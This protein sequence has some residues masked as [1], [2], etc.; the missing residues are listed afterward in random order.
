[1][2]APLFLYLAFVAAVGVALFAGVVY[3][4]G[5]AAA[6]NRLSQHGLTPARSAAAVA[7]ALTVTAVLHLLAGPEAVAA[8]TAGRRAVLRV[9]VWVV[10]L[11]AGCEGI[12]GAVGLARRWRRLRADATTGRIGSRVAVSG[13]VTATATSPAPVTGREAVCWSWTVAVVGPGRRRPDP[14]EGMFTVCGGTGGHRFRVADEGGPVWVDVEDAT[15]DLARE[16]TRS[17]EGHSFG[18]VGAPAPDVER[19][20]G[21]R[22][23]RYTES[24]LEPG[25]HAAVIGTV[26]GRDEGRPVVGD[27]AHVAAGSARTVG[28]RYRRR[29]A[30]YATGGLVVATVGCVG[31]AWT[32][33]LAG[34]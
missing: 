34:P 6:T 27:G 7:V 20:Y 24:V 18:P 25:A 30:L 19:D 22:P 23:R 21:D 14:D 29:A 2:V 11:V 3:Y 28:T 31:L 8:W 32:L 33:G 26:V 17:L 13:R 9:G 10:A 16:R 15:M 4:Q 1:M 5:D 12:A